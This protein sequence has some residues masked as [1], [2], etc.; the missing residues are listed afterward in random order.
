ME[1]NQQMYLFIYKT[2]HING[3]YYIGRH[4]TDNLDDGYL[5]SGTWVK[6]IKDKTTLSRE[7]IV[8]ATSFDELCSLEE[9]HIS[10]HYADPRCMNFKTASVGFT[11]EDAIE[12]VINGTHHFLGENN[13]S[14]IRV[15]DGTHPF[16]DS[17]FAK[18]RNK[19][20]VENG[21]H[22]F[23]GENNPVHDKIKDG[24]HHFLV[25]GF[26]KEVQTKRV[27]SGTH[28]FIGGELQ[29][30]VQRKRLEAGTHNFQQKWTCPHCNKS[31]VGTGM[32]ARWHGDRCKS[33][34][35]M[36]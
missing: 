34:N 7:I 2:T 6:S 33:I 4:Q 25:M 36:R 1:S 10:I 32:F 5:G 18:K 23:L 22:H 9:H 13:P 35:Q 30:E 28:H 20:L 14:R 15:K 27:E 29:K 24:T 11:H 8:E 3:K 26:Q 17:D 16:L 31:G 12:R 21:A 19:K